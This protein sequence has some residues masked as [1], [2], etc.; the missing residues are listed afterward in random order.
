MVCVLSSH[1]RSHLSAPQQCPF[2]SAFFSAIRRD[3]TSRIRSYTNWALA[4][5]I[6]PG[7]ETVLAEC[8][9]E[10][11]GRR[12]KQCQCVEMVDHKAP[13]LRCF[14]LPLAVPS[15]ARLHRA[16]RDALPRSRLRWKSEHRPP[17]RL[18]SRCRALILHG[19]HR[20]PCLLPLLGDLLQ[21]PSKFL[22]RLVKTRREARERKSQLLIVLRGLGRV[23][24]QPPRPQAVY[25]AR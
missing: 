16:P 23:L 20:R 14:W 21:V 5:P 22:L 7:K 4:A 18:G 25:C 6:L 11:P 1:L 2:R 10:Q 13:C 15:P 12:R 19:R 8:V 9:Q 17:Q 3:P 24:P